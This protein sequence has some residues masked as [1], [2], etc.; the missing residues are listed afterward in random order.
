VFDSLISSP[1]PTLGPALMAV[2]A[3]A[4][5]FVCLG[6]FFLLGLSEHKVS[7]RLGA[8]VGPVRRDEPLAREKP[9]KS[10]KSE[11]TFSA[12]ISRELAK[13]DLRFTPSEY[14]SL[15]F[16]SAIVCFILGFAISTQMGPGLMLGLVGL[17]IPRM[18]VRSRQI[19]RQNAFNAQL[20][21]TLSLISNS[22]RSGY[23]L[24]QS[25]EAVSREAPQPT[26]NEFAR[27]VWEVSLGLSPQDALNNLVARIE[28]QDL[29]LMVT[30]INVQHEVGGNLARI[31]DSIGTTIR[32]RVRIKGEIKALTAQQ[33]MTG[34]VISL[35]PVVLG[36]G[37]YVINPKYMSQLFSLKQF[38]CMPTIGLAVIAGL[39]IVVGF[40]IMKKLMAIEV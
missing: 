33:T 22:L 27:V 3:L 25:M 37:L 12:S 8:Y 16:I 21:D 2:A 14:V 1:P 35:L 31:L 32:E 40:L 5:V 24:L 20:S 19:Q 29:D 15:H 38:I 34:Y 10:Q 6:I 23:S 9:G 36:A 39:L 4:T 17:V 7:D 28:S 30:A 11:R 13:A 18:Y 26:A